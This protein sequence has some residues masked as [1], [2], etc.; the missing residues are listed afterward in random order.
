MHPQPPTASHPLLLLHTLQHLRAGLGLLDPHGQRR[1]GTEIV[2]LG[3]RLVLRDRQVLLLR[4]VSTLSTL[5]RQVSAFTTWLRQ[6]STYVAP[7]RR[8]S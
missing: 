7:V 8:V 1:D 2:V 5:L 4:I 3:A 6:V